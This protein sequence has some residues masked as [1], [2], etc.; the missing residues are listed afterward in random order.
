MCIYSQI[1]FVRPQI[2]FSVILIVGFGEKE[3]S[4]CRC[5]HTI[6]IFCDQ[7]VQ[8]CRMVLVMQEIDIPV[9]ILQ[10]R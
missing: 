1:W 10:F 7:R 8:V 9:L 5:V 3:H 4:V 2:R 6:L